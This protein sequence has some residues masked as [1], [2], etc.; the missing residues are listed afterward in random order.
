MACCEPHGYDY[1]AWY[2]TS[3]VGGLFAY[4]VR[5][6]NQRSHAGLVVG[7]MMTV[8]VSSPMVSP[9]LSYAHICVRFQIWWELIHSF[10]C[11][12]CPLKSFILCYWW[13]CGG[14]TRQWTARR[15]AEGKH[16]LTSYWSGTMNR[17][18][19]M[20]KRQ[21]VLGGSLSLNA[22]E[23]RASMLICSAITTSVVQA[24]L[25]F[26]IYIPGITYTY[27]HSPTT[28][29]RVVGTS[30]NLATRLVAVCNAGDISGHYV[31]KVYTRI[32]V[33]GLNIRVTKV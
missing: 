16:L 15:A 2:W 7:W 33:I 9:Y 31:C 30:W 23:T 4:A 17:P 22:L 21:N 14:A 12:L 8:S 19:R 26:A 28:L 13:T 6:E 20:M 1:L 27:I 24:V 3:P 5:R 25:R 11:G 29:P 32:G 18:P 10:R